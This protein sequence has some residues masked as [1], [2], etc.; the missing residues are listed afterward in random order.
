[1]KPLAIA[2]QPISEI[3]IKRVFDSLD[4]E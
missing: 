1:M 3:E 4:V 2:Y